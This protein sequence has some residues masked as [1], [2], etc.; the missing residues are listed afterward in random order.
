VRITD[1]ED[2]AYHV[3]KA[4]RLSLC[5]RPG[6]VYL[7][8]PGDVLSQMVEGAIEFLPRI[9]PP[10]SLPDPKELA[11]AVYGLKIAKKPLVIVGKGAAYGRAEAE[12]TALINSAR[13]PFLPTPMGK[14]VVPDSHELNI[15][16]ARSMALQ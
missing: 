5:G 3:E 1:A 4:V 12:V 6:P 7:D 16:P 8:L 15:S 9:P 13:L 14:G 11:K 2:I 10:I